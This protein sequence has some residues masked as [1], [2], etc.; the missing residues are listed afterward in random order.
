M[1]QVMVVA[2]HLV[3][4]GL[5]QTTTMVVH[6]TTKNCNKEKQW[7]RITMV[8]YEVSTHGLLIKSLQWIHCVILTNMLLL[9]KGNERQ[10]MA[11]GKRQWKPPSTR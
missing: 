7:F 2:N 8:M 4:P 3:M 10:R 6:S 5:Y 1:P 9:D 11:M